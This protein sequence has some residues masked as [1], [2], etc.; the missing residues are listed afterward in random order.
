MKRE[1]IQQK[2]ETFLSYMREEQELRD[3]LSS[4]EFLAENEAELQKTVE[5]QRALLEA[6]DLIRQ[7]KMIPIITEMTKFVASEQQAQEAKAK[8]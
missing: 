3:Q 1:D 8:P 5:E 4:L 7:E 2:M 6:I